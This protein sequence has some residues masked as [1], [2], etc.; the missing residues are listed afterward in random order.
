MALSI[1]SWSWGPTLEPLFVSFGLLFSPLTNE[2]VA[3]YFFTSAAILLGTAPFSVANLEV[4]T[5][6]KSSF[7]F[8][9]Y[10]YMVPM[11]LLVAILEV[12]GPFLMI[13]STVLADVWLLLGV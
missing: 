7:F 12:E 6:C 4:L 9:F 10:V 13:C 2:D 1:A 8:S 5:S 11:K 3:A